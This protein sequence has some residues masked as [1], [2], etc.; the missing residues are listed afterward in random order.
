MRSIVCRARDGAAVWHLSRGVSPWIQ[1]PNH[2]KG[3]GGVGWVVVE[4]IERNLEKMILNKRIQQFF[5]SDLGF[6]YIAQAG[7]K[8]IILV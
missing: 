3:Q 1:Y 5:F 8:L 4:I 7:P 6:C 2:G